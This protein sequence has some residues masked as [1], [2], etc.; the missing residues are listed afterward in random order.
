MHA[1]AHAKLKIETLVNEYRKVLADGKKGSYNEERV[2]I[3]F[4]LPLLEALGWNPRTD[5]VLLEQAT[6]TGRADFG[7]RTG[8]NTQIFVETHSEHLLLRLQSHVASGDLS[9]ND[10]SIFYVFV[11]D[12]GKKEAVNLPLNDKGIFLTEWPEGFFPERLNE[13][14]RL[15]KASLLRKEK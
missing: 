2:K 10:I 6:L 1:R 7:L 3:A 4:I 9:P 12:E 5:E 8:G 15:A 11:N 14:K 13:A